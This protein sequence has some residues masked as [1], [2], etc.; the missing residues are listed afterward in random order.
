MRDLCKGPVAR[1]FGFYLVED[2]GCRLVRIVKRDN[3]VVELESN[4]VIRSLL[5]QIQKPRNTPSCL[6]VKP[7]QSGLTTILTL[8]D[9]R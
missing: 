6:V 7:I 4:R 2:C 1:F 5:V 9:R 3:I 8:R